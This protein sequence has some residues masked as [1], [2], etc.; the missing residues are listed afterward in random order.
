MSEKKYYWMK[1]KRDFCKRYDIAIMLGEDDGYI[2]FYIYMF[3]LCESIKHEGILM[4][5]ETKPYTSKMISRLTHIDEECIKKALDYFQESE[6]MKIGDKGEL[7]FSELQGMVGV[8]TESAEKKRQYRERKKTEQGQSEDNVSDNVPTMSRQCPTEKEK[9]K[10]IEKEKV[11]DK[12][13]T[14]KR[15]K[16]ISPLPDYPTFESIFEK[17]FDYIPS[18][19]RGLYDYIK[20]KNIKDWKLA[21]INWGTGGRHD[22]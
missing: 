4:Y 19:L 6:L 9:E 13:F 3:L 10:E 2:Y 15:E 21:M 14:F 7:I 20:K 16:S 17:T 1:V 11:K 12:S 22:G 8:D 5:S 18:D